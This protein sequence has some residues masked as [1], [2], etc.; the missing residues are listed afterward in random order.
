MCHLGHKEVYKRIKISEVQLN[1]RV[2]QVYVIKVQST[3]D[4]PFSPGLLGYGI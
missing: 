1:I 2:K 4:V 3:G